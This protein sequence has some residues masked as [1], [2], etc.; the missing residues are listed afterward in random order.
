MRINSHASE[1]Y[2]RNA[3]VERP[4][5]DAR[6]EPQASVKTTS[7]GFRLGK[8]GVDFQ[9]QD[10]RL[11]PSLSRDVREKRQKARA[12]E[13]ERDVETL[14]AKI[15]AEGAHYRETAGAAATDFSSRPAEYQLRNGIAAYL[16][17]SENPFPLPG[18]M[19]ASVV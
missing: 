18:N 12:F 7:F 16:R 1:Q 5:V 10:T 4:R 9:S 3:V 17:T 19:L 11:D 15:G 2:R 6:T 8:F 14:R 13:A